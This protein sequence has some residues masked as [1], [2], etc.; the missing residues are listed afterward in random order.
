MKEQFLINKRF[1]ISPVLNNLTDKETGRETRLE[2]RLMDVLCILSA[3]HNQLVTREQLIKEVW[4]DYGGADEGLNQA[5][6]FIRKI[7]SDNNKEIIETIPKKGYILHAVIEIIEGGAKPSLPEKE[8]VVLKN[9]KKQ[10]RIAGLLCLLLLLGYFIYVRTS[11]SD[12]LPNNTKTK[13][14]DVLKDS[15]VK[16]GSDNVDI[17]KSP[18]DSVNADVRK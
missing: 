9:N 3:N 18:I 11:N 8:V 1:L 16:P 6:S 7:L 14:A 10:Y 4:N 15:S 13:G 5:I 12:K 17:K 2:Q